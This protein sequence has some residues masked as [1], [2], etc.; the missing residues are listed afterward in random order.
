MFIGLG[1]PIPEWLIGG[2]LLSLGICIRLEL[3]A[4]RRGR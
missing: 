1:E 2:G 3:M 4:R